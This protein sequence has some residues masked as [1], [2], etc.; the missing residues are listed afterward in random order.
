MA[1]II[2]WINPQG[3]FASFRIKAYVEDGH[4][5]HVLLI[6]LLHGWAVIPLMYLLQHCFVQ[7]ASAYARLTMF[8][9]LSGTASF[10]TVNILRIPGTVW[11]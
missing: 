10:L 11:L 1:E 9:I 3:V 6:L 8:N 7:P 5:L 4:L 2:V